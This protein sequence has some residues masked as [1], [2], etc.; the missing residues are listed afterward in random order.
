MSGCSAGSAN[1]AAVPKTVTRPSALATSC[2]S[3]SRTPFIA[4]TAEAPQIENPVAISNDSPS[5]TPS[6]RPNQRVTT[7]VTTTAT[8]ASTSTSYPSASTSLN[9]SFS[10]SSTMPRRSR[11]RP[12]SFRPGP[13]AAGSRTTLATTAPSRTA[14]LSA[15]TEGTSHATTI[16]TATPA[17]TSVRP[18]TGES[19]V[20]TVVLTLPMRATIT[21]ASYAQKRAIPW[22]PISPRY[23]LAAALTMASTVARISGSRIRSGQV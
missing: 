22:G 9:T 6:T 4:A 17:A 16:A 15:L 23:A 18:G 8:T 3:C 2:S 20:C 12:A 1:I 10:P 7:N 13:V 11:R 21:S 5:P 19:V 14:A